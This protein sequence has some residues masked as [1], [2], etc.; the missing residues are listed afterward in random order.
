MSLCCNSDT[1]G[2]V[3]REAFTPGDKFTS[4]ISGGDDDDDEFEEEVVVAVVVDGMLAPPKGVPGINLWS[5]L[6]PRGTVPPR[7]E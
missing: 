5:R 7:E 3:P 6:V 1:P 4:S 2:E